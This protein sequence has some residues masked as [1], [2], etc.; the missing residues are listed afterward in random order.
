MPFARRRRPEPRIDLA[1]MVD[2]VFNL[3]IFFFVTTTFLTDTGIPLRLPEAATAE[4]GARE[5]PLLVR[6]GADGAVR[7]RDQVVTLSDLE[8]GLQAALQSSPEG[9]VTIEADGR[10]DYETIVKVM[11]AAR[12]ARARGIVLATSPPPPEPA[13]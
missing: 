9:S 11:D 5:E 13:R 2:V 10:V 4:T 1:P 8:S 7:F 3:L 6:I 12:R